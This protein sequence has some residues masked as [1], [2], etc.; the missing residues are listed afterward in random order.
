M[1]EG[2]YMFCVEVLWEVGGRE[3][4]FLLFLLLLFVVLLLVEVKGNLEFGCVVLCLED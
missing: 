3:V 1:L 2:D 4:L